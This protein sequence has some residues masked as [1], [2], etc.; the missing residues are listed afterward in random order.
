MQ[1]YVDE[2]KAK[3]F[4]LAATS[5]EPQQIVRV[6]RALRD[7]CLPGQ[8][9]IHM[10]NERDSR[11]RK[12]ISE[13]EKLQT[14]THVVKASGGRAIDCRRACLQEIVDLALSLGAIKIVFEMDASF[15]DFDTKVI[16]ECIRRADA[17]NKLVFIHL[18]R[19]QEPIMWISDV[20]AWCVNKPGEFSI[21]VKP[22]VASTR[23][24]SR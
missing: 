6:R 20:V 9:S 2:S 21:R 7:L 11:R 19:E 17:K 4:T 16:S 15:L 1:L 13:L 18:P 3:G 23:Q 24:I 12:I 22:L 5:M 8:R 14:Q 10:V